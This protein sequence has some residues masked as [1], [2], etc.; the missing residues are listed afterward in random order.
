MN[1]PH[2]RFADERILSIVRKIVASLGDSFSLKHIL[3]AVLNLK[4]RTIFLPVPSLFQ[5][6]LKF[7]SRFRDVL[8]Q[9]GDS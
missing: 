3:E 8:P 2:E 6:D 5:F 1:Y 9:A 4:I 7:L